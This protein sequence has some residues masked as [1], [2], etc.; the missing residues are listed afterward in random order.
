MSPSWLPTNFF[1]F[2]QPQNIIKHT[3]QIHTMLP[4]KILGF[5]K[6][7]AEPSQAFNP[8]Q[9]QKLCRAVQKG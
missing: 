4:I 1:R 3:P 9:L 6:K 2:H 5:T 7:S 8:N